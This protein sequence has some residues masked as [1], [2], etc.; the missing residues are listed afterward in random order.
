MQG[1]KEELFKRLTDAVQEGNSDKQLSISLIKEIFLF[2]FEEQNKKNT[3]NTLE[4]R[5]E[6]YVNNQ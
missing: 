1:K 5:I 6:C 3:R 4:T 2:M